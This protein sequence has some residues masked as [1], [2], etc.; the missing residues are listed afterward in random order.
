MTCEQTA[1][2]AET[3]PE[4]TL[5]YSSPPAFTVNDPI[6]SDAAQKVNYIITTATRPVLMSMFV[7]EAALILGIEQGIELSGNCDQGQG[8]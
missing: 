5:S 6:P 7:I 2:A 8:Q 1:G 3:A 4:W